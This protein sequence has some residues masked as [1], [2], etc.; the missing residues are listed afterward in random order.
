MKARSLLILLALIA[1][2]AFA[3]LNWA[4]FNASTSL[5]FGVATVQA[6][7]GLIMLGVLA[8][9]LVFFLVFVVSIC[10]RL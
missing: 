2:A 4:A 9:F 7:L 10:R 5:S 1:V 3:M 6:P 8:F